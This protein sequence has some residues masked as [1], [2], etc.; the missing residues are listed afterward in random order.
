M[1]VLYLYLTSSAVWITYTRDF[2][3]LYF[4]PNRIPSVIN[5]KNNTFLYV[6][7]GGKK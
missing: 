6:F 5:A 2:K 1:N 7:N 3:M 4:Y